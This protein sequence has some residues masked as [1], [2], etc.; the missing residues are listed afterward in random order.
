MG[1]LGRPSATRSGS[2]ILTITDTPDA[3]TAPAD[4]ATAEVEE[5]VSPSADAPVQAET[6]TADGAG[7]GLPEA[8]T[9]QAEGAG[10]ELPEAAT[11]PADE[12]DDAAD[13]AADHEPDAADNKPAA[14]TSKRPASRGAKGESSR[15]TTAQR[16]GNFPRADR[17]AEIPSPEHHHLPGWVRRDFARARPPLSNI[18]ALLEGDAREQFAGKIDE[19]TKGISAGRFS[20]AW[21]YPDLVDEGRTL[22]ERQRRD[23]AE[24]ARANRQLDTARR[25]VQDRIRDVADQLTPE[26]SARLQRQLRSAA[27]AESIN[28]VAQEL[29]GV[30]TAAKSSAEKRREREIERTR[31]R[32]RR[33]AAGTAVTAEAAPQ[34]ETWQ[35]VLRRFAEQQAA[36]S[37]GSE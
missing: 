16:L 23:N 4:S 2:R 1:H 14:R 21:Q 9:D 37:R 12:S 29:D 32:I 33:T 19:L 25:R 5:T 36:G 30:S 34:T 31:A 3:P 11:A 24:S 8:A 35:D 15:R 28:A 7:A 13:A 10:A 27:D 18:L 26:V 17:P 20:L 6:P 22:Y